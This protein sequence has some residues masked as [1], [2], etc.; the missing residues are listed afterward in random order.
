MKVLIFDTETTGLPETKIL[1]PD[2][3]DKWPY[4]VQLSYVIY[5]EVY[6]N[7][8]EILDVKDYIIKLPESIHISV[9]SNK[10]HGITD[11]ISQTNGV[12]IE[13][14]LHDLFYNLQKVDRIVGHNISFDLNIIR[15]ELL[16]FIY[17]IS[18]T[19]REEEIKFYKKYLYYLNNFKNIYCTMYNS[20][21]FCNIIALDKFGKPYKKYP[22]LI[23]L[24]FKLFSC[25]PK[26]MH[27]SLHDVAATLRCYIKII[28][29]IDILEIDNIR[30]NRLLQ[31]LH[32]L[33][34]L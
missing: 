13:H 29:G 22:K 5:E 30:I 1:N 3:L 6:E 24:Y 9:E 7:E 18:N 15:T 10:I 19:I 8:F 20:I 14:V 33:I 26:N 4:M 31:P 21:E 16:R 23:D 12:L 32:P 27:N 11:E 17:N 34:D 25:E 2:T 28:R